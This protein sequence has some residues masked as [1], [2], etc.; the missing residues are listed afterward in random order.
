MKPLEG[1]K[2]VELEGLAPGPFCGM[3]L[4]DFGAEVTLVRR[5]GLEQYDIMRH[6]PLHRGKREILLNLK[7]PDQKGML[8]ELVATSDVLIDPFRPGVLESLEIGPD[9]LFEKNPMLVLVRLTGYGQSG[10]LCNKA[11]HDINY[12]S[13]SGVLSLFKGEGQK[14]V[15]P[16]NLLADFAGGGLLAAL[17]TLLALYERERTGKGKVVDVSMTEGV[18]YLATFVFGLYFNGLINN[19]VGKNRLDGGA[20]YYN[21]YETKDQKF[22][23]VGAIEQKFFVEF[24]KGLGIDPETFPP[25][26]EESSWPFMKQEIQRRFMERTRDEWAE[27]FHHLDACVTPVL[28]LGEVVEYPHH[29][30]R[31]EFFEE[32]I[33]QPSPAPRLL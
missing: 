12:L 30:I 22:V 3:I 1:I 25:K 33:M 29:R 14:P 19:P 9:I 32:G 17:G 10:P 8:L 6:N 24:L 5:P 18:I 20:P 21:V 27:I 28:E 2:V 16:L 7:E 4:S 31:G 23:A 15:P 11:G 13:L 26:E